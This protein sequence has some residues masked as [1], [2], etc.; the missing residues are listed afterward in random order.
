MPTAPIALQ[1]YTVRSLT[2]DDF[3][4]TLRKLAA[5]GCT[6][7]E[8]AGLGGHSAAEMRKQ[9]DDLGIAAAGAHV[10]YALWNDSLAATIKDLQVLGC[11]HATIPY[12]DAAMRPTTVADV[13]ALASTFAGWQ[14]ACAAEGIRLAYHNHDFEFKLIDGVTMYDR[15]A[16]A[17]DLDL[18]LD[19]YWAKFVGFD[20]VP[21]IEKYAGR[22]P[23]LH[24]KEYA[25]DGS[26]ADAPFGEGA[27]D[28]DHILPAAHRSGTRWYIAEQDHPR[29]A[30][31]DSILSLNNL[32]AKLAHLGIA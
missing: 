19:V 9:L 10:S 1:L 26:G 31:A 16:A 12:L 14:K 32:R 22:M 24:V 18:Q 4:G 13:D 25:K 7:V 15:L 30:L 23:Q 17:T 11:E 28:W 8:L 21:L 3:F 2:K 5:G 6:A 20:A 29:D 27:I